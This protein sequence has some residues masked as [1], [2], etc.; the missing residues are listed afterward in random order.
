MPFVRPANP[1]DLPVLESFDEFQEVSAEVLQKG[2][3][4]VAG[5]DDAVFA[6]A[7]ISRGFF[8]RRFVELIF[9]HPD[10]RRK[11]L[12][13][14]LLAFAENA[15]PAEALWIST[16]LGNFPMQNVLHR[17]GY[18]HSGVVHDLAM[19]PE[20]IYHKPAKGA[21]SLST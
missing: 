21:K 10:Q 17:R 20:L 19:V 11:G 8:N 16:A 6:Y 14:A 1:I 13:D 12:A 5:F 18:K 9:V 3:C 2:N 4:I 7:I 15:V